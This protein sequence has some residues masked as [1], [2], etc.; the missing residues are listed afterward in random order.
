MGG[1]EELAKKLQNPVAD[2]IS[3]PLQFNFEFGGG[4]DIPEAHPLL[5]LL[6][7]PA[8]RLAN[9]L[10][11]DDR[12]QA[13]RYLLNIQPVIPISLTEDWN[14]ISRTIL[15]VLWQD[16]VL[17]TT[18]QG[19]LGDTVQSLFLSPKS[20]DPF[21]WGAGPVFLLPTATDDS[22]GSERWGMGPTGV[23]LK[24]S[25]PW[26]YG[27]LANHIWSFARDDEREEV[28]LTFLQ[29]FL[30]Y[31]TKTA[32]TFNMN[33]ESTY[34]WD[35]DQWTVPVQAGVSQLLKV[36]KQP[37][38]LGLFGRYWAEGPD[39]APDWS[40]RFVFTFLFPK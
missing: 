12:T 26:T 16:D 40:L 37:I 31:T 2:L 27:A 33:T 1:S 34:D 18:S 15:P 7:P 35:E 23:I 28:N 3:V 13:E 9:R 4:V 21:I 17:G 10:L 5:R 20:T 30:S 25:G 38:S 29:P 14:L 24:Q 6:P 39:S 11:H 22:L 36:G 8:A 19:G 32:T